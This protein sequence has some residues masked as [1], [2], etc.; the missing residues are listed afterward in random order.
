MLRWDFAI[1]ETVYALGGTASLQE[2]YPHIEEHYLYAPDHAHALRITRWG[3][4]PAYQHTV[5]SR[6]SGL[7]RKG[8]LKLIE[9]GRYALTEQ[10]FD[11]YVSELEYYDPEAARIVAARRSLI[12]SR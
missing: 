11:R 9:R 1:L 12:A 5:R 3:D 6:A 10:G 2:T 8:H 7:R 4:R